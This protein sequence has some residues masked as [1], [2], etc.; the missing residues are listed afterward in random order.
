MLKSREPLLSRSHGW[1]FL[2]L[3]NS[4]LVQQATTEAF[5]LVTEKFLDEM[6]LDKR[7]VDDDNFNPW[8]MHCSLSKLFVK[9][10]AW[11]LVDIVTDVACCQFCYSQGWSAYIYI[12]QVTAII[13][14]DQLKQVGLT[15]SSIQCNS[16]KVLSHLPAD[17]VVRSF[18][19]HKLQAFHPMVLGW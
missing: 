9:L 6:K 1:Q 17:Q 16:T 18:S 14:T 12:M 5:C 4:L 11:V 13:C 2:L 7:T 15:I 10:G 19:R 8:K 3:V